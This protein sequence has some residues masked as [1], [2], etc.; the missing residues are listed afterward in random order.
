M[1]CA[2]RLGRGSDG[3][4]GARRADPHAFDPVKV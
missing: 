4:E 3:Y 2:E 1:P